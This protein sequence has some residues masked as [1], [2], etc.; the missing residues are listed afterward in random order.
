MGVCSVSRSIIS[1]P[2]GIS[3]LGIVRREL[4]RVERL[5][6]VRPEDWMMDVYDEDIDEFYTADGFDWEAFEMH[7][8]FIADSYIDFVDDH[9]R[10]LVMDL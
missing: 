8:G 1:I 7:M 4:D 3:T 5:T 9:Q 6:G 2:R 10:D